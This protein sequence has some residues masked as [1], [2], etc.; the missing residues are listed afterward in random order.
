MNC[1]V[2][3]V[4]FSA[5]TCLPLKCYI[6]FANFSTYLPVV[7]LFLFDSVH[8]TSFWKLYKRFISLDEDT[9]IFL[10]LFLWFCPFIEIC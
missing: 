10:F 9:I 3:P 6:Y 7:V 5:G 4:A 8:N 2:F 1:I